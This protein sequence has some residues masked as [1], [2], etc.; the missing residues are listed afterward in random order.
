VVDDDHSGRAIAHGL[1]ALCIKPPPK[2]A[3]KRWR[4][5]KEA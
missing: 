2:A 4:N 5:A 1:E 3:A